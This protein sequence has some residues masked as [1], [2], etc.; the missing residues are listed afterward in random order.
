[1][2]EAERNTPNTNASAKRRRSTYQFPFL[3]GYNGPAPPDMAAILARQEHE[4][5]NPAPESDSEP[6]STSSSL[7]S[8][9]DDDEDVTDIQPQKANA[10]TVDEEVSPLT[11]PNEDEQLRATVIEQPLS[12]RNPS[13]SPGSPLDMADVVFYAEDL[14][15]ARENARR[16]RASN[17][18]HRTAI[19]NKLTAAENNLGKERARNEDLNRELQDLRKE[20][21]GCESK[22]ND[23][24]AIALQ[25]KGLEE[26]SSLYGEALE[27]LDAS[28]K[29]TKEEKN[30]N[31]KLEEE[32][33]GSRT[34]ATVREKVL[35][36]Q[37][38]ELSNKSAAEKQSWTSEEITKLKTDFKK[39]L[40]R[41]NRDLSTG[42][43]EKEAL[44]ARNSDLIV[45]N[46]ALRRREK[47]LEADTIRLNRKL[48][49]LTA[50][51]EVLLNER[52]AGP[53][54]N[55]K[56]TYNEPVATKD[57]ATDTMATP[58]ATKLPSTAT[59][60]D[61][62]SGRQPPS[63]STINTNT[64]PITAVKPHLEQIRRTHFSIGY[65]LRVSSE[66]HTTHDTALNT[67]HEKL[68]EG[69]ISMNKV[70]E[71]VKELV[72]GSSK[73]G[74]GLKSAT[75]CSEVAK[76]RVMGLWDVVEPP[77]Q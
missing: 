42:K 75:E 76:G 55:L 2:E 54:R 19:T 21:I 15:R 47:E 33:S 49:D 44:V 64:I 71:R 70:R 6:E 67:L 46:E 61:L 12:A 16:L 17:D 65:N 10:P 20:H 9:D 31:V 1:M 37:I 41:V 25:L 28:E 72:A 22:A 34:Q 45:N 14:E 39:E 58:Q 18:E 43:T 62:I 51:H 36:Y 53:T 38:A 7:Q 77:L 60:F 57:G 59:L 29:A 48:T 73:V 11:R 4:R 13:L 3:E 30:R 5:Q 24:E 27:K 26:I 74:K 68:E 32:L 63:P 69:D 52:T 50:E 56:P 35:E 23:A 8:L 66:S 40:E